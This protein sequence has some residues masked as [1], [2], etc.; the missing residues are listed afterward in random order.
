MKKR[1]LVSACLLG[2]R[3]K[4]DGGHNCLQQL[5]DLLAAAE[6]I[7]CCPEQLGGL[8][9]PRRAAEIRGGDG[10]AVFS[11]TAVVLTA[12][13]E[14]VTRAFC[15]GAQETLRLAGL[16]SVQGALLKARSPSCGCGCIYD[17][18]F[19]GKTRTGDGVTAALLREHGLPV[20]TEGELEVF[21]Q[22]LEERDG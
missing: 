4:Y 1:I 22:W 18:S 21:F 5:D 17:G 8:P 10:H 7:P 13:G 6:V 11:G 2:Q 15:R 12:D 14:D 19:T 3:T 9:T 20:F 16:L